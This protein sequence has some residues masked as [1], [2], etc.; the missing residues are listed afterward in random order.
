MRKLK[1][2]TCNDYRNCEGCP[3]ARL[4][5]LEWLG[6]ETLEERLERWYEEF[7]DIEI[8]NIVKPRLDKEVE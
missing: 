8:Y 5:C 3:L 7:N 6:A 2:C 1:D 4:N